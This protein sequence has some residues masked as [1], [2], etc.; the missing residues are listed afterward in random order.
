MNTIHLSALLRA[1]DH[2]TKGCTCDPELA[3]NPPIVEV[4]HDATCP[5]G[6]AGDQITALAPPE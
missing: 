2:A 4:L 3:V 5:R 6:E 1:I